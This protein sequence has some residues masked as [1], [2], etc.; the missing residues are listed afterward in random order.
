MDYWTSA[1]N[2]EHNVLTLKHARIVRTTFWHFWRKM[3]LGQFQYY[4]IWII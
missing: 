3:C 4:R 1:N 2:F